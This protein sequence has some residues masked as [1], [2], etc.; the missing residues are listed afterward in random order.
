MV[1]ARKRF[2]QH[3][4]RHPGTLAR[5]VDALDAPSGAPVLEIGPGTGALT[6]V[7]VER[8]YQVTAI[9]KDRDLLPRLRDRFPSVRLAQGDA[10]T[11][12]WESLA[13][14]PRA[15]LYVIGNIPYNITSPLLDRALAPP[16]PR[17]VVFLVQKEVADRLVATPGSGHWSALT[18]GVQTVAKVTRMTTVPAHAFD[19]P[20]K[21]DSAVVRLDPLPV[22]LV[23]D[24]EI[25]RFRRLVT[26]LFASRR[27][28]MQRALRLVTGW[29]ADRV[30]AV[31]AEAGIPPTLRPDALPI[32]GF[33]ALLHASVDGAPA[34]H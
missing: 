28:Q 6:S 33:V 19:P 7:L 2:G 30:L 23:R 9:E 1:R 8:G 4:L 12:S 32:P 27:K 10:L 20:P 25:P 22:P 13:D 16:R 11:E 31:L 26:A 34:H 21:V 24:E 17:R 14:V 18:V 29:P 15:Q 3:F 5:I